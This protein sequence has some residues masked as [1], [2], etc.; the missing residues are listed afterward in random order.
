[1]RSPPAGKPQSTT[2]GNLNGT[3]CSTASFRSRADRSCA[4]IPGF[5]EVELGFAPQTIAKYEE[6]LRLVARWIG[7]LPVTELS[8]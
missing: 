1:M 8:K 7:D 5:A 3:E 2:L 4:S 6:C